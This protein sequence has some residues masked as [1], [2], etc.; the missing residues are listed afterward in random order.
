MKSFLIPLLC[1][2][3]CLA[4]TTTGSA[5]PASK[6]RV[7]VVTGGHDFEKEPF[8]QIFRDNHEITFEA[9]AH[10]Q[11]HAKLTAEASKGWDVLVLYD[12]WQPV[13]EEAKADLLA[14][15]K[16]GKG[17]VSLHHSIANYQEWEAY[18]KLIGG[19]YYLKDRKEDGV[20]HP[21]STY[22][23]DV[24]FKVEIAA[25]DHPVTRGVS[26]FEILDE[27][28]HGLWVDPAATVLLRTNEPTSHP[29]IGWTR[30]EQ[31]S[32]VVYLELGHDH[33]AFAN[34]NYRRLVSQAIRWTAK[35]G[36]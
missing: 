4:A 10:P 36:G 26:D 28:Y 30:Q 33:N 14:R 29:V 35:T 23:H 16:E 7:L 9:V 31:A 12:M 2:V 19:K 22:K 18:G 24:K 20:D 13:T 1:A 6:I 25:Q 11:A 17:L 15:L 34:P 3:F 8:F 32:R 27:T 21:A 5:E